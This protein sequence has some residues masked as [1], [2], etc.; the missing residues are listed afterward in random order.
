M[1]SMPSQP[2][3]HD[4]RLAVFKG[5]RVHCIGIGGSGM[6]GA[7][8]LL[9]HSG[10]NVSGSD[11][12]TFEG[13]GELVAVGATVHFFHS[14]EHVHEGIDFVVRS[15]AVPDDNPE[16]AAA[17]QC[18]IPIICYAEL[19]GRIAAS[20]VGVSVAGT[21]GKTTTTALTA[22][23]FRT[24]G[25]EPSFICGAV[26]PQLGGSSGVGDGPHFIIESCEYARSFLNLWPQSAAIL[27]VDADHLDFYTDLD[28]IIA[29]FATFAGQISPS[30]LL[31]VN[32]DDLRARRA[33]ENAR[34]RV[35]TFGLG[36]DA[37][38]RAC[39]LH[40]VDGCYSFSVLHHGERIFNCALRIA[41]TH[42]VSN[43]LAAIVLAH[44]AGIPADRI[45]E[46][47]SSFEGV[48]RRMT[49]CGK[50]RGV[51]VLDDYAHHP[52]EIRAT[53]R[54]VR[55]RYA[56]RRCWVVFQPHQA[57]RTRKLLK[58]FGGAFEDADFVLIP[59]IYSVRDTEEDRQAINS[60]GLVQL[61]CSTGKVSCY[62]PT[63]EAVTEHLERNLTAGD[64][65]ITMGAGDV[66]KVAD[67]L[68]KRVC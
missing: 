42:N 37:D 38:W 39:G 17:R 7:A 62:L 2:A 26:S 52:T 32:F 58:E 46:G 40:L 67:G 24:A 8:K 50:V 12:Q 28:D 13:A 36:R 11:M 15:A 23:V 6:L 63:F 21:H 49:L 45:A 22:H 47:V 33:A 44:H 16:V 31:A 68:V 48:R 30:G 61:L 5:L 43:S 3:S 1:I 65:V 18:S 66:W 56:P 60:N 14:A 55:S 51:T 54:A 27:N 9:L 29:T 34:C 35:E 64:L 10:A 19:L 53:L 57:S 4:E 20:R 59:D 25:L 41:G